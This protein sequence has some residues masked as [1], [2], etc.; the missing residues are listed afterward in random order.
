M[1][2]IITENGVSL[3]LNPESSFEIEI[4]QPMLATDRIPVPYSTP[5][6]FLPSRRNCSELGYMAAMMLE[7]TVHNIGASIY[8]N[9]VLLMSG[10]LSYESIEEGL[11]NYNFVAKESISKLE[12]KDISSN[13][14]YEELED[15][16]IQSNAG[17]QRYA[18]IRNGDNEFIK[19]PL[20]INKDG[21]KYNIIGMQGFDDTTV[22]D[23]S[24]AIRE[25]YCNYPHSAYDNPFVPALRLYEFLTDEFGANLIIDDS[26]IDD[27]QKIYMLCPYKPLAT[28]AYIGFNR[29]INFTNCLPKVNK[30]E[31]F[32]NI[33]KIFGAAFYQ[34][35]TKYRLLRASS[36]IDST[37]IE[38]W[39]GKVADSF[40]SAF[41]PAQ[42]YILKFNDDSS[43]NEYKGGNLDAD[44][45]DGDIKRANTYNGL[46]VM[47]SANTPVEIGVVGPAVSILH[48]PTGDIFSC[49]GVFS[50]VNGAGYYGYVATSL[51]RATHNIDSADEDSNETFDNSIAFSV[52]RVVPDMCW[53]KTS[54]EYTE[55]VAP[56]VSLPA[57]GESKGSDI[58]IGLIHKNQMT[59]KGI[60]SV[61]YNP[62]QGVPFRDEDMGFSLDPSALHDR[63]HSSFSSWL[64]KNRQM[65]TVNLRLTASDIHNFRMYRKVYFKGREWIPHKL[66]LSIN[67]SSARVETSGEFISL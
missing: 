6:S 20:L 54:P 47:A 19:A 12:N 56:I 14:L 29:F 39:S 18:A 52:V 10:Q 40:S 35:G 7:P 1:I 4:E 66:S 36:I 32:Q 34:D 44:L 57:V 42:T 8:V 3:D 58:I 63:Y 22:A 25:K 17:K 41:E 43:E 38:E 27:L 33:A 61:P 13:G 64:A 67:V 30:L 50:I 16:D 26:I 2:E 11:L 65:V 21:V 60:V 53:K 23:I 24:T 31:L 55:L 49:S 45:A 15:I 28:S 5:I 51:L 9:G 59:D 37:D 48:S 62:S 46:R